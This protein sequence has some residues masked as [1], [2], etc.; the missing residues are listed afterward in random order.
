MIV[1]STRITRRTKAVG[2][3]KKKDPPGKFKGRLNFFPHSN[4]GEVAEQRYHYFKRK[5]LRRRDRR[6]EEKGTRYG[7]SE[8]QAQWLGLNFE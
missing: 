4:S 7:K 2:G 1:A 8:K 5:A 3:D 6:T